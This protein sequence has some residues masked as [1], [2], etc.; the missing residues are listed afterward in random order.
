MRA[1]AGDVD[2]GCSVGLAPAIVM[3]AGGEDDLISA[4]VSR[5]AVA[6]PQRQELGR[7]M[8]MVGLRDHPQLPALFEEDQCN[9]KDSPNHA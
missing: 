6:G 3:L 9:T 5:K 7:Q 2:F 8:S 4:G 1:A